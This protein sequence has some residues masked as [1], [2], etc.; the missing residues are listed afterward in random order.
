[1]QLMA[2]GG[3]P[4]LYAGLFPH[5][6]ISEIDTPIKTNENY[7]REFA[8]FSPKFDYND[9]P[10][11]GISPEPENYRYEKMKKVTKESKPEVSEVEIVEIIE[12]VEIDETEGKS[13]TEFMNSEFAVN[14][15]YPKN[16]EYWKANGAGKKNTGFRARF[17]DRLREIDLTEATTLEFAEA[18]KGSKNDIKQI[19]H[20]AEI[21][22]LVSDVRKSEREKFEAAIELASEVSKEIKAAKK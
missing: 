15:G 20:F 19:S 14:L 11:K 21:S 5:S 18:N 13:K 17:Y 8:S 3:N 10:S 2:R 1:M 16:E 9:C 22:R 7:F 12:I 4:I 6:V